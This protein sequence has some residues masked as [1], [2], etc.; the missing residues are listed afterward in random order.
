MNSLATASVIAVGVL[1]IFVVG[2]LAVH[3]WRR[4]HAPSPESNTFSLT[5]YRRALAEREKRKAER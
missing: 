2:A 3:W 5:D 4:R 1:S